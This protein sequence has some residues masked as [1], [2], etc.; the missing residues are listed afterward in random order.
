M[1]LPSRVIMTVLCVVLV[2]SIGTVDRQTSEALG[3]GAPGSLPETSAVAVTTGYA[4]R[5]G[6]DSSPNIILVLTDDQDLR[7]HSMDFMPQVQTRLA[8]AGMTFSNFFVPLP[9]CCPSRV[10]ILRGQYAHN[11]DVVGNLPPT[12]G[13]QKAYVSGVENAT[14]ATALRQHGYRTALIGKYLN[15]YPL[16][17]NPTYI[18]PGWDEWFS[19]TD[20]AAYNSY[21]YSVNDNGVIRHYGSAPADYITDVLA[22]EASSFI[23][24]TVATQPGTPFF[25]ELAFYA[26][27]A[28]ANPAPRHANLFPRIQAPRTPSFNEADMSDKPAWMQALPPLTEAQIVALD[29]L[30]RHK[31][32]SLQA[33]DEAVAHVMQTLAQTGQLDNT[34]IIYT[35]DNGFHLGQHRLLLGKGRPYEEDIAVPFIVRGP[36]VAPGTTQAALASMIDLA[37]T[38]ADL[39]GAEMAVPVDGRSLVPLLH[40]AAPPPAWRKS[41]LTEAYPVPTGQPPLRS[42]NLESADASDIQLRLSSGGTPTYTALRTAEYKYVEYNDT[43]R[44]LYDL[45]N[46]PYELTNEYR[47]A[48]PDFIAQVS[49]LLATYKVCAGSECRTVD[50]ISPPPFPLIQRPRQYIPSLRAR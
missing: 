30:Y 11:H 24:R 13:F 1:N 5:I 39:V 47:N 49:A 6:Q 4:G 40:S 38:L 17:E 12:G 22:H 48:A 14:M 28:P 36:G 25:L 23:A 20:D 19:P 31:M 50:S 43:M 45:I 37:P 7:L 34:Y 41:L 8:N 46:D 26:P 33:V 2:L 44:E 29:T 16:P 3:T 27:H 10:T 32:Q 42:A 15:G 35:S 18:P 21:N 9:L